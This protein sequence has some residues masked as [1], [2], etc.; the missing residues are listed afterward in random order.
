MNLEPY[1]EKRLTAL[2]QIAKG[3][4]GA[5]MVKS[6]WIV[7]LMRAG[8]VRDVGSAHVSLVQ[9]SGILGHGEDVLA[10]VMD[11]RLE[12]WVTQDTTE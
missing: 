6:T 3:I 11:F 1:Y 8:P 12:A 9:E 4:F 7:S 10:V 2:H 5:E